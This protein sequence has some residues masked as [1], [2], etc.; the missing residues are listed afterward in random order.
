MLMWGPG[1]CFDCGGVVGEANDRVR[2]VHVPD[3]ELVIISPRGK[4]LVVKGPAQA[5][6][7]LLVAYQL[8]GVVLRNPDISLENKAVSAARR[9]HVGVPRHGADAR[10]VAAHHA[11]LLAL[12]C[13]PDLH[14]AVVGSH[15]EVHTS[16]RP[17]HGRDAIVGAEVAQLGDLARAGA[18]QINARAQA[19]RE[20]VHGGP[21]HQVEIEVVLQRRRVQDL[22]WRFCDLAL[23]AP[24][25]G[26]K[27]LR[28]SADRR[29]GEGL[30][31]V[32]GGLARGLEPEQVARWRRG[33]ELVRAGRAALLPVLAFAGAGPERSA[34]GAPRGGRTG[35]RRV[36]A[37][38][39]AAQKHR[40]G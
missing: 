14:L 6:N 18:P 10:C 40:V 35:R 39:L 27:A 5:A 13:V 2:V 24:R 12:D 4:L 20:N 25:A 28:A 16:L 34:R 1:N 38:Q 37:E 9:Q 11:N 3:E 22:E 15:G 36:A 7:L 32:E 21:V 19:D 17:R 31:Q 33:G 30:F 8:A 26:E 29:Q 23:C